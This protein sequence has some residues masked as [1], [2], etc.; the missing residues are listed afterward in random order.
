MSDDR[1]ELPTEFYLYD[2]LEV[3]LALLLASRLFQPLL[4]RKG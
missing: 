1:L 4:R 2:I 3:C